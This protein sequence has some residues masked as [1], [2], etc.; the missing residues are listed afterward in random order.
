MRILSC[1]TVHPLLEATAQAIAAVHDP[2]GRHWL[3]FPGSGNSEWVQRRWAQ[4]AGIAS[5]SQ[6]VQLRSLVEQIAAA[7]KPAFSLKRLTL[8]VAG[9]LPAIAEQL[10]LPK[11]VPVAVV[12]A[13]VLA[14]S[15]QLAKAIDLGLLCRPRGNPW[16]EAPFLASLVRL[17]AVQQALVGH[18]GLMP[19]ADFQDAV[20]VWCATWARR[21]GVP[22]LW[23]HLDAGLPSVLMHRCADLLRLLPADRVHLTLLDPGEV[24]WGDLGTGRRQWQ[25]GE[26]AGP[27]LG[28]LGRC[29]QDLHNQA[30]DSLL[31]EG[32]GEQR[33][34]ADQSPDTLLGRLQASCRTA[35]D[36]DECTPL[37]NDDTS[38][39]VHDC[40]S[41][42]R[43]LEVCRDRI[44]QAMA[45]DDSLL[46]EDIVLLLADPAALAP[47]V[48]AALQ[49]GGVEGMRLPFRLLG[50][51][52]AAVSP[53]AESL[54]RLLAA[55]RGRL[56]LA[57]IQGLIEDP[58]I[59]QRFGF[60]QAAS[61]GEDL[62][63]WLADAHF[64]WGLDA[65]QRQEAQGEGETRWNLLFALR[66]L[67]L[68]AVVEAE[69][70][71]GIVAGV[72]PLDRASG[73][74]VATLAGLARFADHLSS[75]R[76][77]WA[78]EQPRPLLEWRDELVM[79]CEQFL[80][81]GDRKATEHRAMLLNQFLPALVQAA[82]ATLSI[83]ADAAI[84]LLSAEMESLVLGSGAGGGG[85]T[86]A[87]LRQYAGVPARMV[88]I[89][90]LGSG[91]FPRRDERPTWHP[92]A[93]GGRQL[94]DPD[95]R[96]ADRHALLL[97]LLSVRER[98]VLTY[99]GG[100]D[101]DDKP[102]PPSTP[103]AD[104]LAAIDRVAL[105]PPGAT[106]AH[107]VVCF[108][109]G[110]NGG[111][112]QAFQATA[113]PSARSFLLSDFHAAKRLNG[114]H[115]QL[116]PGLWSA[117]LEPETGA[118]PVSVQDLAILLTEPCRLFAR[119]VGLRL[120]EEVEEMPEGDLIN[121]GTLAAWSLR[122]QL[123]RCRLAGGD[124]DALHVRWLAAGDLPRG[125]Y[126]D[127]VW[128]MLDKQVGQVADGPWA[129]FQPEVAIAVPDAAGVVRQIRGR[130]P[131]SWYQNGLKTLRF[132]TASSKQAKHE[133][134]VRLA[135]ALL[136]PERAGDRA[137][138]LFRDG[139]RL[140]LQVP[141]LA[142]AQKQLAGLVD[143]HDLARRLPLPWWPDA[144]EAMQVAQQ[145]GATA[146]AALM[147]GYAKWCVA[148]RQGD[149]VPPAASGQPATRLCF[150]GLADPFRWRP[151]I[152]VPWLPEAGEPW[153]L[154]LSCF[155]S[156]GIGGQEVAP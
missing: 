113:P 127:A 122:D 101:M 103:L 111:S 114:A 57:E 86:V 34:D 141:T 94:G 28:H 140:D 108:R 20:T 26:D 116:Y 89:A 125:G 143:L 47:L 46:P 138:A 19:A 145:K 7:G 45:A 123:L 1:S 117:A 51:G 126:G 85:I 54:G 40:R 76:A 95:L 8:V 15:E 37:A 131:S 29:A 151:G 43:E 107:D 80:D 110:L 50:G 10:P 118:D 153:A 25:D 88:V 64:R 33:V 2:A 150:R 77:V 31:S 129:P 53:V 58:L 16:A 134:A 139:K 62:V 149:D 21:G 128:K 106:Q 14:W 67:G 56:E 71:D 156:A 72:A 81:P 142:V 154:R 41:P 74:G 102:R 79:L 32:A 27:L 60:D 39:T 93:A 69:R 75:A 11:D 155:I 105:P 97:V 13:R 135:L 83:R 84:R 73:L 70:R 65:A 38:L 92:L 49:P 147:L 22:R 18:L 17:P 23:I 4:V 36:P 42:L 132:H 68:G 91:A 133:L 78:D 148:D 96:A 5:H 137:I 35:C 55:L 109:H 144:H 44:L 9:S 87:D 59:A 115:Q 52:G 6:I 121:P 48:G 63:S 24:F 99:Q 100:S 112:P 136:A 66:R 120:P 104:L 90:G 119:R 30:I 152:N 124:D 3:I 146:E 98:L 12:D 130:L 61:D 82:P